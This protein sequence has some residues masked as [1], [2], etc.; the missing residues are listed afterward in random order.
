MGT[1]IYELPAKDEI[2]FPQPGLLS[3]PWRLGLNTVGQPSDDGIYGGATRG[4]HGNT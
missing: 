1:R 3:V 4:C 2:M